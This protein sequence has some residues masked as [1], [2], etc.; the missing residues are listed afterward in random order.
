MLIKAHVKSMHHQ[1]APVGHRLYAVFETAEQDVLGI[2]TSIKSQDVLQVGDQV[3]LERNRSGH[4][5][6]ALRPLP[7]AAQLSIFGF[8]NRTLLRSQQAASYVDP[9][10]PVSMQSQPSGWRRDI[11]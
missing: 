9:A 4:L 10:D 5:R 6:L 11:R 2:W 1:P 3:L 8:L 7:Y